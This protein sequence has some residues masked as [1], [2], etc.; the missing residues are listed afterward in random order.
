MDGLDYGTRPK[1]QYVT[2]E[3]FMSKPAFQAKVIQDA[4]E[5]RQGLSDE[6]LERAFGEIYPK[7]M[8]DLERRGKLAKGKLQVYR[9]IS[10]KTPQDI[11]YKNIGIYWTWDKAKAA[12]YS[13]KNTSIPVT[14]VSG[15]VSIDDID[16]ELNSCLP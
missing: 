2:N 12:N 8:E 10:V 3:D 11:D 16:L 15:L 7:W 6:V 5:Y 13:D 4:K 1:R 14:I 9:G